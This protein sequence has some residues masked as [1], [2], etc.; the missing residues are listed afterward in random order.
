MSVSSNTAR[1]RI[2]RVGTKLAVAGR[3]QIVDAAQAHGIV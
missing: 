1:T 3:R 2:R